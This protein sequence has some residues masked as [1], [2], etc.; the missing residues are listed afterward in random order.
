MNELVIYG[1]PLSSYVRTVRL[2]AHE[3]GV[4]YTLREVNWRKPE[5]RDLH[6][7]NKM[8]AMSHGEFKLY[9][10][11]A[12]AH[13]LDEAFPGPSLQPAD[14]KARARMEQ[15]ISAI[16]AY[17]F[18][19]LVMGLIFQRII[20]PLSGKLPDEA[21]IKAMLPEAERQIDL[22]ERAL[23]EGG[24]LAGSSMSLADLFLMPVFYY[25]NQTPEG[26][27][28]LQARPNIQ[29]TGRK[30]EALASFQAT[31]PPMPKAAE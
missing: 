22:V 26:R 12:I 13:Y 2:A 29:A 15:W 31:M 16:N 18:P 11:Q 21:A 10:A 6:P 24:W 3:K 1:S 30:V 14:V 28:L 4:T 27:P 8:P 17:L 5:Y 23:A 19:T 20:G 25:L 7:F 9:E